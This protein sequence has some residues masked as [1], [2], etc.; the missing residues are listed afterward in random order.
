MFDIVLSL[1]QADEVVGG[2]TKYDEILSLQQVVLINTSQGINNNT[3][4]A[5]NGTVTMQSTGVVLSDEEMDSISKAVLIAQSMLLED[6][7]VGNVDTIDRKMMK[8]SDSNNQTNSTTSGSNSTTQL[9]DF[10][11]DYLNSSHP[12]YVTINVTISN[13]GTIPEPP[14]VI[15]PPIVG[16][17][18]PVPK[19][20]P[21]FR[22]SLQI[23]GIVFGSIVGFVIVFYTAKFLS[24]IRIRIVRTSELR[25]RL[26]S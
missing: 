17:S 23:F 20:D 19:S 24:R 11:N 8:Q 26:V 1:L 10:V 6:N 4:F 7:T 13:D 14:P 3:W 21:R 22:S 5:F 12:N 15:I 25:N 9:E 18:D 16:G 2:T